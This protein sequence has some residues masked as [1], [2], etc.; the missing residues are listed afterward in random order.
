MQMNLMKK[1]ILYIGLNGY[2][3]SGKDTLAKALRIML[4]Y[5]FKTF[6]DFINY[7]NAHVGYETKNDFKYA[8]YDRNGILNNTSGKVICIAFADQLKHICASL[9]G[10]PVDRF[11]YNK[12]NAYICINRNFA[13]MET[14]PDISHII[15]ADEYYYNHDS[16]TQSDENYYMSLREVLVYVGTYMIQDHLNK[17]TFINIVNNSVEQVQKHNEN[18]E[19]AICTDVRFEHEF[20]FIKHSKHGIMINIVRDDIQQLDNIAEHDLDGMSEYF[21]FTIENNGTY[22]DMFKQMW[23]IIHANIEFENNTLT[24]YSRDNSYNYLRQVDVDKWKL[25]NEFSLQSLH[26]ENF[27]IK[28]VDPIGGPMI[29]EGNKL[30]TFE[31][32]ELEIQRIGWENDSVMIYV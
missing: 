2:A 17:N 25:C 16:Y 11:Y 26:R 4:E 24:L 29:V 6:D 12:A 19:F 32:E 15:S 23:D 7:Y 10:I 30:D 31:G 1:N 18:A 22:T 14:A 20:D 8:T 9:F 27:D 28:M 21:D 5:D 13:Y 3:G